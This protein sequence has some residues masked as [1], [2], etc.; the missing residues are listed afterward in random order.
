MLQ[1]DQTDYLP[2]S[3]QRIERLYRIVN[4]RPAA[5]LCPGPSINTLEQR[6]HDL[7]KENICWVSL[8]HYTVIEKNILN[9][10]NK[11]LS[12]LFCSAREFLPTL[13]GDIQNFLN[14]DDQNIFISSFWR[15]AYGLM[16]SSFQLKE[17]IKEYDEKMLFFSIQ[18]NDKVPNEHF[19]LHL[20][21]SNSLLG[22]IQM[23]L[24]GQPQAV[25]LFGADGYC[26][27]DQPHYYRAEDDGHRGDVHKTIK[28]GKLEDL[29]YDTNKLFNPVARKAIRNVTQ[30]FKLQETS[31]YN[32][33]PESYYLPFP[34]IAYD[35]AL[36]LLTRKQVFNPKMD[37]RTP[38]EKKLVQSYQRSGFVS[39]LKSLFL[40]NA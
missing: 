12:V 21:H 31:I 10:I 6:I 23:I 19:P 26:P 40:R 32:C 29:K 13:Y 30:T 25:Y 34:K 5:I 7:K 38:E 33:S 16:D 37:L 14:R 18:Q 8:N 1:F 24:L 36:K 22:L 17:F 9:Q 28:V 4:N 39:K 27:D 3:S 20:M 11:N 2:K 15:E 35:D